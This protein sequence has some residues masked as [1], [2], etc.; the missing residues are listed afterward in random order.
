MPLENIE[1]EPDLTDKLAEAGYWP[2]RAERLLD[3]GRFAD[4]VA[5]CREQLVTNPHAV[6]GRTFYGLALYRAEQIEAAA[7]QFYFLLSRDP[8][9]LVALKYLGDIKFAI[10]DELGAMTYYHRIQQL[11]PNGSGIGCDLQ[12]RSNERT[13]TITLNR[14]GEDAGKPDR[15]RTIPFY[16]ETMGDLYL[17]QGHPRLAAEVYRT[18]Y[19]ENANPRL[20]EKLGRAEKLISRKER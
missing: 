12:P 9:N 11:D 20:A 4:A 18:I 3:E 2:A 15:S 7:E 5:L 6:A 1:H 17:N 14:P 13:R 19:E 10:G 16:T 8:D